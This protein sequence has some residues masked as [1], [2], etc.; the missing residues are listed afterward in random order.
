MHPLFQFEVHSP[1]RLF[2]SGKVQAVVLTLT[3]GEIGVYANH[4]PFSAPVRAGK[5]RFKD[6]DGHWRFAL[7][8]D[9]VLEV[10]HEKSV[11]MVYTAE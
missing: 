9:G 2:F 1:C 3:D 4:S 10:K 5:L 7:V 8:S 11:L 6:A